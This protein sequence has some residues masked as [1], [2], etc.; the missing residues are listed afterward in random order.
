MKLSW[1]S[2]APMLLLLMAM[3]GL[4]AWSW[5]GVPDRLPVHWN[6]AGE[7]DGWGGK[8][9]ALLMLPL[10]A[11]FSYLLMAFIPRLDPG[12]ANFAGFAGPYN[13][14]RFV[15]LVVMAGLY[16]AMNV[17]FR[18]IA[19]N[20]TTVVLPLLGLLF[21]VIGWMMGHIQPN[22][23][24]G[25]RTPW[26]LSSR[27]SWDRSHRL[28][29]RLFMVAGVL[30]VLAGVVGTPWAFGAAIGSILA[31]VIVTVAYSYV[32]WKNDPDREPPIV[33]RR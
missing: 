11:L 7:V 10:I 4:A 27:R 8:G 9:S 22:W 6:A 5:N 32:V 25:I 13:L 26:T 24:V 23:T 19:V 21:V 2:E 33:G 20:M 18:G 1:K 28:G 14:F 17:T 12:R 15:F 29:S 3:F 31:V 30:F 16:V